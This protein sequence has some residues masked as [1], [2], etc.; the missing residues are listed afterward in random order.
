MMIKVLLGIPNRS[1][2]NNHFRTEAGM[3]NPNN[4]ACQV[5][6]GIFRGKGR[7]RLIGLVLFVIMVTTTWQIVINID[8][9]C[10]A[11]QRT[12][13]IKS[14]WTNYKHLP[15]L[16]QP[17]Q[18]NI[19]HFPEGLPDFK[20]IGWNGYGN[21]L[22]KDKAN[23]YKSSQATKWQQYDSPFNPDDLTM[24]QDE[25]ETFFPGLYKEIERSIDYYTK[26]EIFNIDYLQ[27]S[28]TGEDTH[29]RV[30]IYNN[31]LYLKSYRQSD[32]T[33][34]Q[35]ALALL[36]LAV[37]T[38][39]E[40]LPN[41]EFCIGM[42]DWGSRGKFSLDRSTNQDDVWLM[43]DYGWFSWPEHVGSYHDMREKSAKVESE[44]GW[45]KKKDKLLWRGSMKVGTTDRDS[46]LQVAKGY[47][48]SDVEGVEWGNPT[49]HP[50]SMEDHCRWKF[51]GFPEG[52]TYSGRLRYL[53]NCRSVI[54]THEPR[55]IQHWTHLYNPDWQSPDQNIVFVPRPSEQDEAIIVHDDKGRAFRDKTWIKLPETM[56]KL[57]GNDTLAKKIADN[58]WNF[59]RQRFISPASSVCYWRKA[60]EGFSKVQTYTVE[61]SGN[62]TSYESFLLKGMGGDHH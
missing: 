49:S 50:I 60:L 10:L 27:E 33:R 17:P 28:C 19:F 7:A 36:Y 41:I 59:F 56:E 55:W 47:F 37:I 48:W 6:P 39:R 22:L 46:L 1:I 58:Q 29:A 51:L 21:V 2:Q 30:M 26:E 16:S 57:L 38:S 44:I 42:S 5:S 40:K 18:F 8:T 24:T 43:P 3:S 52:N 9:V 15:L 25:C 11:A 53:Q 45:E 4:D 32:F 14:D 62:E 13:I 23:W 34:S 12:K 20:S 61:L 35:A 54:I 31:H